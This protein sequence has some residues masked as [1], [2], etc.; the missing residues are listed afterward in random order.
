MCIDCTY[1][2]LCYVGTDGHLKLIDFGLSRVSSHGSG[3]LS[4]VD[5]APT[6]TQIARQA[7]ALG[8]S[9]EG[10][11][12]LQRFLPFKVD[13]VST[14]GRCGEVSNYRRILAL[15]ITMD[16]RVADFTLL[17]A[18][19]TVEISIADYDIDAETIIASKFEAIFID[20]D[21]Y[22]DDSPALV[23]HFLSIC[24]SSKYAVP[25]YLLAQREDLRRLGLAAGAKACL[26]GPI[27]QLLENTVE[28]MFSSN[29]AVWDALNHELLLDLFVMQAEQ[30]HLMGFPQSAA[31][32]NTSNSKTAGIASPST[33]SESSDG[34]GGGGSKALVVVSR[35]RF[36]RV[37]R[38]RNLSVRMKNDSVLVESR[39]RHV[40]GT[41]H[42][43]A[44]EV[45]NHQSYSRAVDWW[46]TGVTM[47]EC[48]VKEHLFR[49]SDRH[50][51]FS[52]IVG[53]SA[54]DLSAL[55][56][57][58]GPVITDL[59]SQFLCRD[60]KTRLGTDGT[61]AIKCH[62]AFDKTIRWSTLITGNAPYKPIQFVNRRYRREDKDQ[63]Y[64][65]QD[66]F[67][68]CVAMH[69]LEK[70]EENDSPSMRTYLLNKKRAKM[71]RTE[72]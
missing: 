43:L 11:A 69:R 2:L 30:S 35:N 19:T 56:V 10:Y 17:L 70:V 20:G 40:V 22:E 44:P 46:A 31:V 55:S 60:V 53:P 57:I 48:I 59:V 66:E 67:K 24:A 27:D 36:G 6:K 29:R 25:V 7:S 4:C 41:L 37:S 34:G 13:E 47:Y 8:I 65:P 14:L 71:I 16:D 68:S 42:Y 23:S 21:Y 58:G 52:Q 26:S 64:G 9:T 33:I 5:P 50:E 32:E 18:N 28:L 3:S 1:V 54:I 63:F 62:A 39:S 15:L 12:K 38:G 45:I 49:G 51:V 61:E 72:D